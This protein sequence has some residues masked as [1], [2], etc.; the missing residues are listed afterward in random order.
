MDSYGIV[1]KW[2]QGKMSPEEVE[3]IAQR[4]IDIGAGENQIVYVTSKGTV[5]RKRKY[6][7]AEKF[8]T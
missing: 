7:R 1:Y 2:G 4:V 8:K 5:I 6:T 3:K